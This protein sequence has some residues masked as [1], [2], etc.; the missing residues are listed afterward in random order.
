[1]RIPADL[2][3]KTAEKQGPAEKKSESSELALMWRRNA[4]GV[5]GQG[6]NR[7]SGLCYVQLNMEILPGKRKEEDSLRQDRQVNASAGECQEIRNPIFR[8]KKEE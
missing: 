1:M 4:L 8:E 5:L 3:G 6:E 2:F 7:A